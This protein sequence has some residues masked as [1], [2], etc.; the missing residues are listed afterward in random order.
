[1]TSYYVGEEKDNLYLLK[2]KA[3]HGRD[4]IPYL[5]I[6]ICVDTSIME[7]CGIHVYRNMID[8]IIQD[9]IR[10]RNHN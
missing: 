3:A 6:D 2:F 5:T 10:R 4:T 8:D 9:D 1:M 7:E